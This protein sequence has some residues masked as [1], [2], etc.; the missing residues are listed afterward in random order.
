MGTH[1]AISLTLVPF[2]QSDRLWVGV[3]G[4]D[5]GLHDEAERSLVLPF[6]SVIRTDD[7]GSGFSF[8]R[9]CGAARR[10]TTVPGGESPG[11]VFKDSLSIDQVA[12]N[13]WLTIPEAMETKGSTSCWAKAHRHA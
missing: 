2:R 4:Q 6:S 9:L 12:I 13:N 7:S 11:N 10:L 5:S 3:A 8:S 1:K